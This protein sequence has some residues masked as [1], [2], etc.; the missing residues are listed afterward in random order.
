MTKS[1]FLA[2]SSN[3]LIE[4]SVATEDESKKFLSKSLLP[5]TNSASVATYTGL[6][7]SLCTHCHSMTYSIKKR[8]YG[9]PAL[10]DEYTPTICGK[11]GGK[12]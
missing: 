6:P 4:A 3:A 10:D 1:L 9:D 11:C 8:Q 12:K 7:L 2:D 5:K